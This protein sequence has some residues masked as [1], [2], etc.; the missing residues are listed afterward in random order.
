LTKRPAICENGRVFDLAGPENAGRVEKILFRSLIKD[1]EGF[2]SRFLE[3]RISLA[4]SRQL[5][6]TSI[7]PNQITLI[8]I[9]IGLTGA[10]LIGLREGLLQI[11][12]SILFLVHSIVDGCDGEIARLKF[13]ESKIGGIL[14]FWGDNIVHAAVF[15]AIGIEWWRRTGAVVPLYLSVTAVLGTFLSALLIYVSTMREKA[16]EGPLYTSVSKSGRRSRIV[17]IAD[18]LS[19]RDFIYLVVILAFYQH[20]DWFLVAAAAGTM[21][22]L[23]MLVWIR[24]RD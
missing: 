12:G 19:R 18:F 24:V 4:I 3:R 1:T 14:D 2:M 17:K 21:V 11:L 15:A 16:S 9:L 7:T 6:N 8:S 5:V 22:F 23:I 10:Y 13:M 20:I